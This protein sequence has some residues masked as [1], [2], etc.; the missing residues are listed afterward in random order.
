MG[1]V[2]SGLIWGYFR[3]IGSVC[4]GFGSDW[5]LCCFCF[6]LVCVAW[7]C[8]ILR[9]VVLCCVARVALL[10]FA[11]FFLVIC[12]LC[13]APPG[14]IPYF[15]TS[16]LYTAF[17]MCLGRR[18]VWIVCPHFN[19]LF[20]LSPPALPCPAPS[21]PVRSWSALSRPVLSCPVMCSPVLSCPALS[22]PA[23]PCPVLLSGLVLP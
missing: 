23:L 16:R 19:S 18:R 7:C 4:F 3:S 15:S 10:C 21:R 11:L 13:C 5:V 17:T 20:V 12:Y 6:A 2:W 1:S 22:C 14:T 9:C 8:A